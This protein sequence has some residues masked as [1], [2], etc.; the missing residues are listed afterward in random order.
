VTSIVL[1]A[2][3][4]TDADIGKISA[5]LQQPPRRP[6]A[7]FTEGDDDMDFREFTAE[8]K[9]EI[10][11]QRLAYE[12]A[13]TPGAQGE[14]KLA[15]ILAERGH[16]VWADV[17]NHMRRTAALDLKARAT[18]VCEE[19]RLLLALSSDSFPI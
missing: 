19:G 9:R 14:A 3:R 18:K 11:I 4:A 6:K 1:V 17:V 12:V 15:A 7:A 2:L 13:H 16:E 10:M 8:E 5:H